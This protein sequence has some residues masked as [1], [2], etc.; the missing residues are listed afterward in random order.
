MRGRTT[1][2]TLGSEDFSEQKM[3]NNVSVLSQ[4][5]AHKL[6]IQVMNPGNLVLNSDF[7]ISYFN[8]GFRTIEHIRRNCLQGLYQD[9][10][11]IL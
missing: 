9:I 4:F 5:Y 11:Y 8:Y 10:F 1:A 3:D 2:E 7:H 6:F